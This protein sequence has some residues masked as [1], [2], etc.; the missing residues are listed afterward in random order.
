MLRQKKIISS[1]EKPI[2]ILGNG[3]FSKSLKVSAHKFSKQA[4]EKIKRNGG[5]VEIIPFKT[6]QK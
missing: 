6:I 2:K 5:T 3:E 1:K 4:M